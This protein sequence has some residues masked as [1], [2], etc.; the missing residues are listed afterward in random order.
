VAASGER[1][2][3]GSDDVERYERLRAC[4]LGGEPDGWRLGLALLERGG[5]AAWTRAWQTTAPAPPPRPSGPAVEAPADAGE[6]VGALASMA[7]AC[8]AGR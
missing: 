8:L 7:L 3:G 1:A 6:L 4:A 2:G 5:I